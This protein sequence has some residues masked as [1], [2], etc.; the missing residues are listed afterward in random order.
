VS[1]THQ[2]SPAGFAQPTETTLVEKAGLLSDDNKNVLENWWLAK[3]GRA[4]MPNWDLVS[5]CNYAGTNGLILVEA[6]AHHGEFAD[7]RCG[8]T[9]RANFTRIQEALSEA[10]GAWNA[11]IPGFSLSADSKYQLSNRFA[12]AWKVASLGIPVVLIY[13]GFLNADDMSGYQ[14]LTSH[15]NWES[16]VKTG[17]ESHVPASVW[18]RTF[19]INETPLTVSIRS[20]TVNVRVECNAETTV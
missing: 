4:N 17:G 20:A 2:W 12:F 5:E 11:I 19:R 14:L 7:D 8:A 15:E 16:C 1:E 13:L 3:P 10:N 18:N 6:K 9:N